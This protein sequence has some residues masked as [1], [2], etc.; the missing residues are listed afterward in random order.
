[1][2]GGNLDSVILLTSKFKN[3]RLVEAL[4]GLN[5][6]NVFPSLLSILLFHVVAM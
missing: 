4:V 2:N 3:G 5:C 6:A 1:M